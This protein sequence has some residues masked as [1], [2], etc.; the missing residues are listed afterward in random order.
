MFTM[1]Y[2][3]KRIVEM[4]S[5]LFEGLS[6]IN[7]IELIESL[8]KSLKKEKTINE[9]KFYQSFGA[10]SDDKIGEKLELDIKASRKFILIGY[11]VT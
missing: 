4:Y 3:D 9:K 11:K 7:K 8:S 1:S 5:D 10:F 6:S 2:T